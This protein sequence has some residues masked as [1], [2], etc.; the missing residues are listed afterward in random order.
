MTRK[1]PAA[2][3]EAPK[4]VM[5]ALVHIFVPCA[6]SGELFDLVSRRGWQSHSQMPFVKDDNKFSKA[7]SAPDEN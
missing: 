3:P 5:Y 2:K 4:A 7:Y 1:K 6:E